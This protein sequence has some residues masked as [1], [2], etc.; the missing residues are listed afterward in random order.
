LPDSIGVTVDDG[1]LT[2][3]GQVD[4]DF[5]RQEAEDA[6]EY[7]S[8]VKG[9]FDDITLIQKPRAADVQNRSRINSNVQSPRKL[10]RLTLI[11]ATL[12]LTAFVNS[13]SEDEAASRASWSVPGVTAVED[14]LVVG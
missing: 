2:L 5:Q 7:L 4:S 14:K 1:W 12:R 6:V 10:R 9:V 8:G 11:Q 13:S 3:S